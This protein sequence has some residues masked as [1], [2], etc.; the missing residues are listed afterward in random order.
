MTIIKIEFTKSDNLVF[1]YPT[2]KAINYDNFARRTWSTVVDP[3]KPDT[4]PY[5]C[6]DNFNYS[7]VT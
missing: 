3:I 1:P 6:R 4:T 7:S 2:G 5:N